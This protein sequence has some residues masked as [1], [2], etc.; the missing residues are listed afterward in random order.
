MK[1]IISTIFIIILLFSFPLNAKEIVNTD[2]FTAQLI[3]NK[4]SINSKNIWIGLDI[5]LSSGWHT[6]WILPGDTGDAPEIDWS[7]SNNIEKAEMLFPVPK[8]ISSQLSDI[9]GYEDRVIFPIKIKLKDKNKDLDAKAKITLLVCNQ[10][11]IPHNFDLSIYLKKGNG[12][13]SENANYLNDAIKKLP[14]ANEENGIKILKTKR[15]KD[16]I[17]LTIKNKT[18]FKNPDIFIYNPEEV[19]FQKPVFSFNYNRTE[20]KVK[21]KLQEKLEPELNMKNLPI[22]VI[23]KDDNKSL[24]QIIPNK[25]EDQEKTNFIKILLIALLGGF[26]LNFMPCVLPVLSLKIMSVLKHKKENI[27][28][29]F[30]STSLGII[31]SFIALAIITIGLKHTGYILGWGMHFQQPLFLL[32]MIILLTLF[33]ANMWGIFK[34]N[35]PY[36]ITNKIGSQHKA[37]IIGD[38]ATGMFATLLATPCSAP[39]LGTAI[40]FALTSDTKEILIIFLMLGIGMSIPF[41]LVSI[42]PSI[43]KYFPKSGLWMEKLSKILSLGLALTAVW[44]LFILKSQTGIFITSLVAISLITILAFTYFKKYFKR[45]YFPAILIIIISSFSFVGIS[46][47]PKTQ[48]KIPSQWKIFKESE[49]QKE[50][51]NRKVVFVDITADWCLN[52]KFNKRFILSQDRVKEKLFNDKNIIA[53]KGDWTNPDPIIKEFIQRHGRYGIPFNAVF[54]KNAPNGILLPE[55]LTPEIIFDALKKAK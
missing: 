44:L 33:S 38:F 21:V 40:A 7:Q 1:S 55:L 15:K 14:T 23:I 18:S 3:S 41:L 27:R 26:I 9:I 24:S 31:T 42:F 2:Q 35:L 13:K 37:N 25:D 51:Q 47:V 32:F 11:C 39:F 46:S 20:A 50:I 6:Y 34:I 28:L 49:I 12:E 45:L 54:G 19:L 5:N 8:R 10:I 22:T 52:C 17:E 16:S 4:S 48:S 30:F 43:S 29:S 53:M 36:W